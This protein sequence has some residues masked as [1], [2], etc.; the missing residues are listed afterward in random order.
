MKPLLLLL[1]ALAL[2]GAEGKWTPAQVLQL[3]RA[4]LKQHGGALHAYG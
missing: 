1:A 4:W 2:H 3:D